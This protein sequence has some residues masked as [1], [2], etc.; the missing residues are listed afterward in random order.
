[1]RKRRYNYNR[2]REGKRDERQY[3]TRV[4]KGES[5]K[6]RK[7]DGKEEENKQEEGRVGNR[8]SDRTRESE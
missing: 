7:R 3:E 2:A 6:G 8:E 4:R 1:M 5:Q